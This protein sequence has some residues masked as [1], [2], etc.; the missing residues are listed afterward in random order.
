MFYC[1]FGRNP[2]YPTPADELSFQLFFAPVKGLLKRSIATAQEAR[3][4]GERGEGQERG[5]G[6]GNKQKKQREK[7]KEREK[8]REQE[9]KG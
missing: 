9:T 5:D 1:L 4:G 3:E 6:R 7:E 2:F 8:K